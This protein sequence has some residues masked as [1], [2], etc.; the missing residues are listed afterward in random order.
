MDLEYSALNVLDGKGY[1]VR[2]EN[3]IIADVRECADVPEGR[4]ICPGGLIDTQVNGAVGYNYSGEDLDVSQV[5]EICDNL[6]RHG[7]LQHFATIITRPEQV[8]LRNLDVIVKATEE[9][10]FVRRSITGIHIEGNFISRLDGPRGAHDLRYVRDADIGEFDRWYEH[11][12][13]LLKYITIGA[14]ANGAEQLI[15]HAVSNGVAVAIGHTGATREQIDRAV[16]A[17]ATLSTHLGNGVFA[18]LDRFE[19][20]IWPQL[21]NKGLTTGLIADGDHVTPDLVWVI[22]RCKDSDHII[23][24]SDLH[25]CAGLPPGRRQDG[26]LEIDIVKDGAVRVAGTPYL[27]GAGVHL[28]RCIWNYSRFTGTDMK[29]SFKL[30]TFNP[31]CKYSLDSERAKLQAGHKAEFITFTETEKGFELSSVFAG[32][33]PVLY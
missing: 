10:E 19:N 31:I 29:T 33:M 30:G 12:H 13:G 23:L 1:I 8:I 18:K 25:H 27:A 26:P 17:G 20:P 11:A 15:R 21:R 3:G 6:A 32:G 9:D 28:I 16:E 14:E 22:S 7:T 4:F 2:V 5:R 24:V